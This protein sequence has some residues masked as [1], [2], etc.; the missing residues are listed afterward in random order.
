MEQEK[1]QSIL[2]Q[3]KNI[4]LVF[5][6]HSKVRVYFWQEFSLLACVIYEV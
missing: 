3:W 2:L 5:D 1:T 4:K 6:S